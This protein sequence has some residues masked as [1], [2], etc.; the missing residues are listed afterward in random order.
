VQDA[1]DL[2]GGRSG[3]RRSSTSELASTK[4]ASGISEASMTACESETSHHALVQVAE[5]VDVLIAGGGPAG[6]TLAWALARD[7]LRPVLL[8]RASFPREKVCG[9]YVDPRGLRVL[10]AMGALEALERQQRVKLT[11]T[12]AFVDWQRRFNGPIPIYGT[13]D[14][15]PS[16]GYTIQRTELDAA[17]LQ[18]AVAAGAVVHEQ[19]TIRDL[20]AGPGGV[21]VTA[22][23]G[24]RTVRYSA[25]LIAGAD[26]ANS[27]VARSQGLSMDDP[28]RTAVA[29]RAYGVINESA[30]ETGEAD[31]FY[32]RD[33]FPGFGW[34]FTSA[35]GRVNLGLGILSEA[36]QR[37]DM[38]LSTLF[39]EFVVSLRR[40][41]P[42]CATLKLDSKPI[43]GVLKM[44]GGAGP[45]HFDG[46]LLVGDA[47]CFVDPLTGEG[48]T[49][50]MES[51][52]LAAPVLAGAL[53]SGDYTAAG[54]ARY[55]AAFRAYFDPSMMFL[56]LCAEMFRNRHLTRPWLKTIARGAQI[57]Q[58]DNAFA[59]TGGSYF[60]GLDIRPFDLLGKV[61]VRSMEEVLLALPGFFSGAAGARRQ[62][63]T[64]PADLVDWSIALSRS[65]VDDPQWHMNW[66]GDIQR[67][68]ARLLSSTDGVSRDPRADGLI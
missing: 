39:E 24:Q 16:Y 9:D 64:S 22:S 67:Q 54:L 56:D 29:R 33:S 68:W 42:R 3:C 44:Y 40:H 52:L 13:I 20:D 25:K 35:E 57:A 41:H 17:M 65:M 48:I 19:T 12:A 63:G 45:N 62:P 34:M 5:R 2:V 61:W 43:G 32:D 66:V 14:D 38:N 51:A 15:L 30:S 50:A 7:G 28:R 49:P 60:G 10:R 8:E 53:E 59:E 21:E 55:E 36:R 23:R 58:Q 47:G 1:G 18:A 6:S 4:R 26:G 46:G 31:V 11:S 37:W 27:V